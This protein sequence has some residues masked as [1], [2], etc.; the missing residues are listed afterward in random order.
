MHR[1]PLFLVLLLLAPL[2][3]A[4]IFTW[5]DAGGTIHFS[6]APPATGVKYK[7]ITLSGNARQMATAPHAATSTNDGAADNSSADP[8][9]PGQPMADTPTNRGKV[10]TTLTTNLVALRG[11]NPVVMTQGG[12]DVALAATQRKAELDSAEAQYQLYCQKAQ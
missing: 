6:E 2:A 8:A 9:N 1:L 4:Q 10:C 3:F 7:E 5:T 12:K 11:S